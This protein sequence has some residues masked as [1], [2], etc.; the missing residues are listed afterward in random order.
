MLEDL[1]RG[2]ATHIKPAMPSIFRDGGMAL[3]ST[4]G[5]AGA[6]FG[7]GAGAF[8][9]KAL[10]FGDYTVTSNTLM[11]GPPMFGSG[12]RN[13][14]IRHKEY[15]GDVSSST[16]FSTTSY[17]INPANGALFPWLS[18]IAKSY[19][20]YKVHGMIM[21]FN[22]TSAD[23]LNSTN[24]ALG[25]VM[26]ATNYDVRESNYA[27]KFEIENTFFSTSGKPSEDHAH[28]IECANKERP[29]NV[30]Y[31]DNAGEGSLDPMLYYSGNFQV[32]TVGSQAAAVIGELWVTYDIELMKPKSDPGV[33]YAYY[34]SPLWAVS[35][36]L[37]TTAPSLKEGTYSVTIDISTGVLTL[38][39]AAAGHTF[40]IYS[41]WYSTAGG[42]VTGNF[43]AVVSGLTKLSSFRNDTSDTAIAS[44]AAST[45]SGNVSSISLRVYAEPTTSGQVYTVTYTTP[46]AYAGTPGAIDV[47]IIQLS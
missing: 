42:A 18:N 14:R 3:G 37:G 39:T 45:S 13:V 7:R 2:I 15:I 33:A 20:Q 30:M 6:K 5:P 9:S 1:A 35:S 32:A 31:V 38:P 43:N 27:S 24:T 8:V 47:W 34:A 23:A 22:S 4:F 41:L 19:Q 29:T 40:W 17:L 46:S 36:P 21:Y 44:S 12:S 26:M 25:T 16:L 11:N 28:P 10:G